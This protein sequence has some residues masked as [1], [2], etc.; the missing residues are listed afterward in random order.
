MNKN[1]INGDFNFLSSL[2]EKFF[3]QKYIKDR[4]LLIEDKEITGWEIWLQI[5][6]AFFLDDQNNVMEWLREVPCSMDKRIEKLK[7]QG[8]IDFWLRERN[9]STE[10]MIAIELK[11]HKDA[12]QC[13][14]E[15]MKDI[16][17][18]NSLKPSEH[19]YIRSFWC[20][21]VHRTVQEGTCLTYINENK[22]G[23]TFDQNHLLSQEIKGTNFSFTIL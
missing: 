5:E 3:K 19:S 15:M 11:Q 13:I 16:N 7:L 12:K 9:K 20:V 10:T 1:A 21:G 14:K 2:F 17:K 4:L 18:F 8:I 6:L 22:Q 23:Y